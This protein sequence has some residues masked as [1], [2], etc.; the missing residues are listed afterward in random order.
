MRVISGK[1]KGKKLCGPKS[2]NIRP[3]EDRIKESMFNIISP[4]AEKAKV[5]DLFAG[6]GS[7]GIEFLSRGAEKVIFVD[8]SIASIQLINK[9]LKMTNFES[10]AI[11]IRM[12]GLKALDLFSDKD[13]KFDYIFMDPP[14]D[15]IELYNKALEKISSLNILKNNGILIAE[16][17][18]S[19]LLKENY[20]DLKITDIRKYGNKS[21][22]YFRYHEVTAKWK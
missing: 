15:N 13:F 10:D 19:L 1:R 12:D 5:L 9:N 22:T 17:N 20:G 3:T 7:I 2:N 6:T 8:N 4:I 11:V 21:M 16:H 18:A 14:Y